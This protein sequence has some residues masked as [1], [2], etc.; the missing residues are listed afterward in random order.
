MQEVQFTGT[1]TQG[2]AYWRKY[3]EEIE[4][5]KSWREKVHEKLRKLASNVWSD[6]QIAYN[7]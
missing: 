6:N 5:R 3:A 4:A 2:H 1:G 7:I